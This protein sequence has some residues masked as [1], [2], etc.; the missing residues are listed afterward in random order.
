M[1]HLEIHETRGLLLQPLVQEECLLV[2]LVL[3]VS[4]LVTWGQAALLT[5]VK[6][7]MPVCPVPIWLRF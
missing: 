2:E 6:L 7:E 5:L 3:M 1:T 4:W